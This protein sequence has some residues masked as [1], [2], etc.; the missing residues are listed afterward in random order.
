MVME[1]D[2][3]RQV[4]SGE[5]DRRP[6]RH[7]ERAVEKGPLVAFAAARGVDDDRRDEHRGR[8]EVEDR[9]DARLDAEKRGEKHDGTPTQPLC[10]GPEGGEEAVG[11]R[12][13]ADRDQP[14]HEHER[15][16]R[17]RDGLEERMPHPRSCTRKRPV[18]FQP[19][20]SEPPTTDA[21]Q[22]LR[23]GREAVAGTKRVRRRPRRSAVLRALGDLAVESG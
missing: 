7:E 16:P 6:V 2:Q 9:R 10:P 20:L 21:G 1:H 14:R 18:G 4:R 23:D 5:E 19:R 15:R 17:L 8:V 11:L 3:V 22:K 13:G 12:N